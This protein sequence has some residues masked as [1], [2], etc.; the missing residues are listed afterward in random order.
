M[1]V[2]SGSFG[3]LS[4]WQYTGGDMD[5]SIWYL[6][7][8]AWNRLA[9]PSSVAKPVTRG[10]S[11]D[12]YHFEGDKLVINGWFADN[13]ATGKPYRY[14]ILT[15]KN[16]HELG[17]AKANTVKR[18]DVVKAFPKLA[19][20]SGFTA[21][22]EYTAAMAQKI[23]VI[24]RYTDDPAGNGNFTDFTSAID[25]SR[26]VACLD[27]MSVSFGK[28]LHVSGWFAS[29]LAVGK[30]YRYVILYD[31]ADKRELQRVKIDAVKRDDVKEAEPSVYGAGQSGFNA[32]FDYSADL[33]GRK[34]QVVARYSDD[35]GG[36]GNHVDYWFDP[37][38][39]PTMLALDGKTEQAFIAHSVRVETQ[40]DGT[41]MIT[42]K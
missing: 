2:S 28:Q 15:D 20:D 10:G 17:R 26:S 38:A 31:T 1:N 30:R 7:A 12:G 11:L 8:D 24:L 6:D 23:N 32:A 22:L 14:V 27:G 41:V 4:G 40:K 3:A 34:L 9:A 29:D 21:S 35:A 39:G 5:R 13:G 18:P 36:E 33:I 37:F 25:L 16:G 42:A 19:G